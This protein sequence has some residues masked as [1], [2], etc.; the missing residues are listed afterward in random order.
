MHRRERIVVSALPPEIAV[1]RLLLSYDEGD[2][3]WVALVFSDVEGSNPPLPWLGSDLARVLH[4]LTTLAGALTPSPVP[5]AIAT[6][7]TT[8]N[9]LSGGY[10][11]MI[12]GA[13]DAIA[14]RW[15]AQHAPAF[16]D[17]E[18]HA[19]EA[20]AGV[21]LLHL[22]V[23][24]DNLI[25]T[26][27]DVW[28]V[29]W[30]HAR[31]GAPWVD[32]LFFAPSVEMQGGPSPEDLLAGQPLLRGVDPDMINAVVAAIAG[33]FT[34]QGTQPSPPGLPTVRAFQAVQGVVARRWLARRL[35][36]PLPR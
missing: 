31:I 11:R 21:S 4:G 19:A 22:D 5:E 24:S 14:G 6:S 36:L 27:D 7:I 26:R 33:F 8:W 3:G 9:V 25:L 20:A 18:Q 29:D 30:A 16:A 15:I 12:G 13:G 1:P 32:L 28:F 23:R 35:G 17:V 34:W 2:D 10:W